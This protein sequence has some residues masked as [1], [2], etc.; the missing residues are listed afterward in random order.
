MTPAI[1]TDNYIAYSVFLYA[2]LLLASAYED[3]IGFFLDGQY[4]E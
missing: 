2:I 3:G 4:N 1:V